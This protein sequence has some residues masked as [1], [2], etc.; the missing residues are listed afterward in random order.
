MKGTSH[1]LA[2]KQD[3]EVSKFRAKAGLHL[4]LVRLQTKGLRSKRGNLINRLGIASLSFHT[5]SAA[6][7]SL[8]KLATI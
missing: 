4:E 3:F 8:S 5:F 6:Y 1:Y 7:H 2:D